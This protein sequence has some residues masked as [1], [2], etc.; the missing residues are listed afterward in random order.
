MATA[1]QEETPAV[2]VTNQACGQVLI[3]RVKEILVSQGK[4]T[5]Q[6][7]KVTRHVVEKYENQGRLNHLHDHLNDLAW[8]GKWVTQ[9]LSE[10]STH[11]RVPPATVLRTSRTTSRSP[12]ERKRARSP[13]PVT[14]AVM[15]VA[16]AGCEPDA[17]AAWAMMDVAMGRAQLPEPKT[18]RAIKLTLNQYK[19]GISVC[20]DTYQVKE[21]L[22]YRVG[23]LT[24]NAVCGFW[25]GAWSQRE[26]ISAALRA[27]PEVELTITFDESAE[28]PPPP[29]GLCTVCHDKPA[30]L[31]LVPCGHQC[32]CPTCETRLG[33]KC[34][35]C[36]APF[37]T[38]TKI[39]RAGA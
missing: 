29:E 3:E 25:I 2:A 36:R 39:F 17:A 13:E 35:V 1:V 34:P 27:C 23:G 15:E 5:D 11:G 24:W 10:I 21:L 26:R 14:R 19:R 6:A 32:C 7:L 31:A 18:S 37:C 12:L 30:T 4:G 28:Q 16:E 8:I 33:G 38:A 20:G 9:A 22:K